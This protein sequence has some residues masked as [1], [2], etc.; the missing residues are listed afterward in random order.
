MKKKATT[1][2]LALFALTMSLKERLPFLVAITASTSSAL[3]AGFKSA[4]RVPY[5]CDHQLNALVE[6]ALADRRAGNT[7]VRS[8]QYA[9]KSSED[10]K[11]YEV[12]SNLGEKRSGVVPSRTSHLYDQR[13]VSSWGPPRARTQSP[14]AKDAALLRRKDVYSLRLYSLHVGS[15]RLSRFRDLTPQLFVQDQELVSR[16]K[17]WIRR[18]LQVFEF[19]NSDSIG[20]EGIARRANN[21]EFL[22]EYIVAILK[23]VDVKGSQAEDMLQEFLG[24]DHTRLFL[25]ELKAWLRSPHTKLEDWDRH[26]QYDTATTNPDYRAQASPHV[27]SRDSTE[28]RQYRIR[29]AHSKGAP[30]RT[31]HGCTD[32]YVPYHGHYPRYSRQYPSDI[33]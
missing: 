23:S 32:R 17:K 24:R 19:L 16:A 21:A 1:S 4:Q 3:S 12:S 14:L 5:V 10:F 11:V 9:W 6:I 7:E 30:R 29:S 28:Q 8:V 15:N 20:G 26:V 2:T 33:D 31:S 22:L 13:R 25:H 27:Q 18:E